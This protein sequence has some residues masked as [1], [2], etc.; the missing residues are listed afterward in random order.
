[1][2][3]K[4]LLIMPPNWLGDVVMAQ[5]AMSA[6]A[7]HYINQH[8]YNQLIIYGRPWLAD[9]LPFLG[10]DSAIY[11]ASIPSGIDTTVLF[12]NSFRSAWKAFRSG[13]SQRIGFC[14]QWRGILLNQGFNPQLNMMHEHHRDYFL[15]LA[16]QADIPIHE[17]EVKL[18]VS[19]T[20]IET[21]Q[22]LMQDNGLDPEKTICVAP[23]AQFGGAKRYPSEAYRYV[24]KWLAEAGWHILILG[25]TAEQKI[26]DQCLDQVQT[27]KWNSSGQTSLKE[28][29][30][31]LTASR[32]LLCNDSGLM[33]VAAGMGKPV[34]GIFG[35]TDPERTQ[36]SGPH[37]Q[38]LYKPAV[39]SPCLQRECSVP[40]HPCMGNILPET[41][42]DVCLE[43]LDS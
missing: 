30:Q 33:H 4:K 14:G 41:V 29:L 12:P 37:V 17:R 31:I 43:M 26:G 36:P 27:P 34:V 22:K 24:L 40:G 7:K 15:N 20:D 25:T 10:L 6:F 19:T 21:G 32:L 5:P 9:L 38:L 42:R 28:A 23:G 16:E 35:A 39:C 18:H 1:M 13:A 11:Q 2:N 3:H 8:D